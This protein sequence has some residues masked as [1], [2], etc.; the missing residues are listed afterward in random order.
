MQK[1]LPACLL[2]SDGTLFEGVSIGRRDTAVGETVF[3]TG[4]TGY[5]ETLT[6]PS[7]FGQ[8]V[9]QTYPFIGNYGVNAVDME[10]KRPWVRGYIV[11]ELCDAPSNFRCEGELGAFLEQNGIVGLCGIDTRRLTRLIREQGVMNGAIVPGPAA[12]VEAQRNTLLKKIRAYRIEGAVEAVT[13]G[14]KQ[15][16]APD[17]TRYRV[18][19]LDFGYKQ[20]ILQSLLARG[21]EVTV[22]PAKTAPDTILASSCDG[23]MLTNG[24]GDP[25]DNV[26]I[27]RN[28]RKLL[29]SGLPIFGIC[30]GHQLL[31]LAAGAKTDKLKYGH[32][33]TNHPVKDLAHDRTYITSQN[34]G[35]AVMADSLDPAAGE[36][37]HVNLNDGTVEGIRYHNAPAFTVQFHPEASPGPHDSSYLFD[38]FITLMQ[39][40]G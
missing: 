15:I 11:R 35:Y 9:T 17:K 19:L 27:I 12:E 14:E 36:V 4:M 39:E 5:E 13:T 34:H 1:F 8:I 6:D 32:R 2:L 22:W 23:L 24:P 30:L 18:A 3:N 21:C 25:A 16:F 20:N 10:S 28:L 38:S 7:Y 40:R 29:H 26:E 33:G 31:A 37:S